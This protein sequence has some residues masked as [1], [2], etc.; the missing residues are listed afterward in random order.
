MLFYMRKKSSFYFLTLKL[1]HDR[2]RSELI[3]KLTAVVGV[4]EKSHLTHFTF[5]VGAD[6]L[7]TFAVCVRFTIVVNLVPAVYYYVF[8]SLYY[9]RG[10]S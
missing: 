10:W 1:G 9:D 6:G 3:R 4:N 2:M 8:V 5:V 7:A